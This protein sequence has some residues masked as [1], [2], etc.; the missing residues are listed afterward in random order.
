MGSAWRTLPDP[1][2]PWWRASALPAA[3]QVPGVWARIEQELE[4]AG[5]PADAIGR[6]VSVDSAAPASRA[7]NRLASCSGRVEPASLHA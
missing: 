7:G 6:E 1:Y 2:G 5:G 3:W 4:A